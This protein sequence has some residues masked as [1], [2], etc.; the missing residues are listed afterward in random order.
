MN[1]TLDWNDRTPPS[2]QLRRQLLDGIRT[3]G[4]PA[5]TRLPTVRG[6]AERLGVA[7]G[8]VARIYRELE[9]EGL[10]V[11][12]GRNGTVVASSADPVLHQAEEAASA[13]AERMRALGV[14]S[15]EAVALV[16]TALDARR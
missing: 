6:L 3:G 1:L 12:Q 5:G 14:S 15:E 16:R 11:T 2:E 13:F 7:P 8:T 9:Q 4:L 10:V